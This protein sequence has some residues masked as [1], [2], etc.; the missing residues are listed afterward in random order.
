MQRLPPA[1]I[2]GPAAWIGSELARTPEKWLVHL[3]AEQI[4]ELEAAAQYYL[5]LGRDVGEITAAD[6]PLPRFADHLKS[7]QEKLRNGCG[8]EVMRGLPVTGYSQEIAA[9]IFCGIGAH[10]GRA[11]SQ[12]AQG[13]ILGH[14]RDTGASSQ[15]PNTR[16]YLTSERQSFHTDSSD[17]VGLLC[18]QD[19]MEGGLSLLV[20]ALTIHNR[21]R[22]L[23]PDL[24]EKLYDP[25]ATDRRGEIPDGAEP[26]M[27]IPVLNWHHGHLTVFYQRQYI[28]SAQRFPGA[29]RLSD[30]HIE[31]LDLFDTLANDP[32]LYL[33]MQLEPGDMQFVY[34]HTQLHDRTGFKDW[35]ER[36]RRR[37]LFRLWLSLP[38]D[39]SLPPCFKERYGSIDVGNRGGIITNQTRLHAPLD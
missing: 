25:I 32:D 8:V 6:F 28:D 24:L 39:R 3:T 35:P 30:A 1:E 16:I 12:N 37:H 15:D 2:N 9:T 14:V 31:A 34:N 22:D 26:Y 38:D 23:R 21:M 7:L 29:L 4:A 36:T 20:S 5:S 17:V 27:N 11:R 18:L 13:H 33:Q 19:A 10:I